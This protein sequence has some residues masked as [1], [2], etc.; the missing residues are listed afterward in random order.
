MSTVTIEKSRYKARPDKALKLK[1]RS[2][3]SSNMG[4]YY[5]KLV[6][7]KPIEGEGSI[8]LGFVVS[9]R[10]YITKSGRRGSRE[11][12]IGDCIEVSLDTI[13]FALFLAKSV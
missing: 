12:G 8:G 3:W 9:G 1:M 6:M 5:S 11:L 4:F 7:V 2:K 13:T 10:D